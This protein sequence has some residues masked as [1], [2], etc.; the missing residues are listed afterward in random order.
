MN[1]Y[2]PTSSVSKTSA[3]NVVSSL[4]STDERCENAKAVQRRAKIM[5]EGIGKIN[6]II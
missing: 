4:L 2:G 5:N 3:N 1:S 6:P